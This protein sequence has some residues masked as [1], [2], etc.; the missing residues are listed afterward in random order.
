M[1]L[2]PCAALSMAL[3]A[4]ASAAEWQAD[5]V[6]TPG[7]VTAVETVG[8]DVRIAIGPRWYR[9]G[10][11]GTRLEAVAAPAPQ[12]LPADA[13]SDARVV[14][15]T[16]TIARAWLAEPTTRYAHGV[17]GD[18]IEAGSLVI[19]RRDGRRAVRRLSPDAVFEDI[20]PRIVRLD[21]SERIIVVKSY[22]AR[23]SAL[24]IVDAASARIIG[25]TPPIGRPHAWLNPA[26]I[27]DYDGDGTTD[28]ALV[29]QPH[30][31][32]RLELWSWRGGR[33]EKTAETADA[34]NHVIGS[35]AL[36]MSAIADFNGDGRVDL[37]L[38]SLDRRT[39]RLI[40]FTPK[41]TDVARVPVPARITTNIGTLLFGEQVA[42]V[43]GLENGALVLV[44][45]NARA[46][47]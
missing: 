2:L 46:G 20:A 11:D 25:E 26:G 40:A 36:E 7:R 45:R 16:E 37:A 30:F 32:G 44:N 15:G 29:R 28:I 14:I 24:A 42:L 17:L 10:A 39:L 27:A 41:P 47:P 12:A 21:G 22:L 35:R 34:S 18:A 9:V 19:E 38:P 4:Q 31:V 43:L 1:L 13:L 23:G 33:L 5:I 8:K 3:A 6:P